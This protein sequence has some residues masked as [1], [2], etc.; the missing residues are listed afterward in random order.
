M[1]LASLKANIQK[2]AMSVLRI[3]RT[4]QNPRHLDGCSEISLCLFDSDGSEIGSKYYAT[5]MCRRIE[6]QPGVLFSIWS[7]LEL[8]RNP[9][10]SRKPGP[11]ARLCRGL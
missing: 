9:R 4:M 11:T 1:R 3:P 5:G 2:T 7:Y 6:T 8:R 10:R